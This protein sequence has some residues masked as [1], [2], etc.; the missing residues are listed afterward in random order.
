M[1]VPY[2]PGLM[3][4]QPDRVLLDN[5]QSPIIFDHVVI[6]INWTTEEFRK[7]I[8]DTMRTLRESGYMH[9]A[10]RLVRSLREDLVLFGEAYGAVNSPWPVLIGKPGD[11][12]IPEDLLKGYDKWP[13]EP[14]IRK[15]MGGK[16]L[17]KGY[18]KWPEEPNIRKSLGDKDHH[19]G[20][21]KWPEEPDIRMSVIAEDAPGDS[22]PND[23]DP[24]VWKDP[25]PDHSLRTT[26]DYSIASHCPECDGTGS[27]SCSYVS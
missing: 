11:P 25:E 2:S 17:L 7:L 4:S 1:A 26:S 15:S 10:V 18:D 19:E 6:L 13:E 5:T 8:S 21:D 23:G 12:S 20:Y 14:N 24:D 3:G 22:M 27:C 16:D 9:I